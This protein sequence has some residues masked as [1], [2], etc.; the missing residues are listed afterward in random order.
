MKTRKNTSAICRR[1]G[2]HTTN[3]STRRK[4]DARALATSGRGHGVFCNCLIARYYFNKRLETQAFFLPRF[5]ALFYNSLKIKA[6]KKRNVAAS[7]RRIT[8]GFQCHEMST[9][10]T[11]DNPR[12]RLPLVRKKARFTHD[13]TIFPHD[14]R[15][16]RFI[17]HE[18]VAQRYFLTGIFP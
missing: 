14:V 12:K 9:C 15:R 6:P 2:T 11:W 7:R 13:M 10:R 16:K 8:A 18:R 17:M 3:W 5:H 1:Q 4:R